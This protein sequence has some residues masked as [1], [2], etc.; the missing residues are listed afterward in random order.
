[1]G[2]PPK[3]IY[4]QMAQQEVPYDYDILPS[5][6]I[7]QFKLWNALLADSSMVDSSGVFYVFDSL[8][9]NSRY[10]YLTDIETQIAEGNFDS[11]ITMM[12]YNIDS[13][14]NTNMDSVTQVRMADGVAADYI[15]ENYLNF[16]SLYMKYITNSLS[17]TDSAAVMGLAGLWP[18][19]NGTVVYQ[20]RALY[21]AIYNDLSV[22]NDDSCMS[23]DSTYIGERHSNPQSGGLVQ[24]NGGQVYKLFPNPN[25][26]NLSLS[27]L[28]PDIQLVNVNIWDALGRNIYKQSLTFT[29]TT[30]TLQLGNI[31]PGI[32]LMKLTDGKGRNFIFK[33][34][35]E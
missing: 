11:A 8:A 34:T 33:F 3:L 2:N 23:L 22:F 7:G 30:Q 5:N 25:N 9:Q 12:G 13:M 19:E 18:Q 28:I 32:Y 21:S 4:E 20:A 17:G 35:V 6:W 24:N 29:S 14:T 15:V 1:V 27:Q 10:A 31:L 26:G 16:Y